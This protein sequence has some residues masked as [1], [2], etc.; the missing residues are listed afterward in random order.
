[1]KLV[2]PKDDIALEAAA[3]LLQAIEVLGARPTQ[4]LATKEELATR[5]RLLAMSLGA[6]SKIVPHL[7]SVDEFRAGL[8]A[9]LRGSGPP[10]SKRS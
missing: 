5:L 6:E 4:I 1:M 10:R 3:M 2:N 7:D 9:H 8:E